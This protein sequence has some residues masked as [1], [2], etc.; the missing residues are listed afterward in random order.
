MYYQEQPKKR[1]KQQQLPSKPAKETVSSE[2][3]Q[4]LN[5]VNKYE[6]TTKFK[7]GNTKLFVKKWK[8]STS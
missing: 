5:K 8:K 6:L 2:E 1:T 3:E 7:V 4:V